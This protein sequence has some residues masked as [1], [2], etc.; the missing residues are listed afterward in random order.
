MERSADFYKSLLDLKP[1]PEGGY[2][3]VFF[4]TKDKVKVLSPRYGEKETLRLAGTSIH[5]ML[6]GK[7]FSALHNL[8]S[9]EIWHYYTGN[10]F[11]HVYIIQEDGSIK[12]QILGDPAI[13]PEASFQIA[14]EAKQIFG[15][16]LIDKKKDSF[17]LIGCTVSPGFDFADFK[18]CDR[19]QLL[20]EYPQHSQLIKKLTRV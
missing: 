13:M 4:H 8:N 18:I 12:K 9:A 6:T 11:M 10:T 2:Y 17:V 20:S 14:F 5:Y 16:E 3:S 7:D 19:K 1:H 15:A